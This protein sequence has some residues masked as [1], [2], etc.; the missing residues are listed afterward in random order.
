MSKN[1]TVNSIKIGDRVEVDEPFCKKDGWDHRFTGTVI[2]K[3]E[4][5]E[6]VQTYIVVEDM[7]GNVFDVD[8]L[9]IEKVY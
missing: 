3:R 5:W 4:D 6:D 2:E 1:I 8:I 9:S 7:D